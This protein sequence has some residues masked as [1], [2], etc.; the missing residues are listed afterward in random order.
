MDTTQHPGITFARCFVNLVVRRVHAT[1]LPDWNF[2][3]PG[4]G[5][6]RFCDKL[7]LKCVTKKSPGAPAV[8]LTVRPPRL[9]VP[10][11][12]RPKNKT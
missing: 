10:A 1:L 11:A 6:E 4:D 2:K 7:L 12:P 8:K 9:S 5:A 3:A